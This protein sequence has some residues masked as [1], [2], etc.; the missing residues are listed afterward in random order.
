[1][2]DSSRSDLQ[3]QLQDVLPQRL[4]REYGVELPFVGAGMAF[5]GGPRLAAAVSNAG[6]L[7]VLAGSPMP[8]FALSALIQQTRQLTKRPF[9]VDL[10]VASGGPTGDQPFTGDEHIEV[11]VKEAVPLVVF[12]WGTPAERWVQRL[13]EAGA[14]VWMQVGSV[15]EAQE[16][17]AVGVEGVIVQGQEAGGHNRGSGPLHTLLPSVR[18]AVAPRLVLAAGGIVDGAAAA[19]AFSA[20]ADG[21]WV[22]SRLVASDEAEAHPEY[23]RRITAKDAST[24]LTTL[25]GPEWPGQRMRVLCNRVVAEWAGREHEAPPPRPGTS[26]GRTTMGGAPYEMP[27]FSAILPSGETTGDFEQMCLAAGEG[28]SRIHDVR[29]AAK[30]VEEMMREA[31]QALRAAGR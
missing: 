6:G 11:C 1:M 9:G 30:I 29:P 24:A 12:F 26:I 8:P 16:A 14:R 19:A 10:L 3:R 17:V 31:A 13:H 25:F 20:G 23:K 7:G 28:V 21:V 2:N 15:A 27:R 22:G 18:A 4:T 5:V